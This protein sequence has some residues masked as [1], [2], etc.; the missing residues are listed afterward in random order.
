MPYRQY[1]NTNCT[2][3]SHTHLIHEF[4]VCWIQAEANT[5]AFTQQNFLLLLICHH[6]HW[7]TKRIWKRKRERERKKAN[8]FFTLSGAWEV[9]ID[10]FATA[11]MA[12][13][14][15]FV[16][17]VLVFVFSSSLPFLTFYNGILSF[18]SYAHCTCQWYGWKRMRTRGSY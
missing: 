11:L 12:V 2:Y 1:R 4:V 10:S 5:F 18:I 7:K 3:T 8:F 13:P 9:S 15:R 6:I 17:L 16:S 14:F